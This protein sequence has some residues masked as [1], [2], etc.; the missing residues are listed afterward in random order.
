MILTIILAVLTAAVLIAVGVPP[1]IGGLAGIVVL[2]LGV[3]R[4]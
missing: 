4:L 3:G 2:L 1:V